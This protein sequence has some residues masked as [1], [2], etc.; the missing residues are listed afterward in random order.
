MTDNSTSVDN[1]DAFEEEFYEKP[2]EATVEATEE[3]EENETEEDSL[4]PEPEADDEEEATETDEDEES[5]EEPEEKPQP[6]KQNRIQKRIDQLL[7]RERLANERAERLEARLAA[8]EAAK[9]ETKPARQEPSLREQLPADAPD[10]DAK[11]EHGEPLY[12][13]GQFDPKYIEDITRYTFHKELEMAQS[14][15]REE[16][17]RQAYE[18]YQRQLQAE[19]VALQETWQEKLEK[20]EAEVP[21]IRE[22]LND[23]VENFGGLDPQYGEYLATTLMSLENGPEVMLYLSQNIGEAQ[24]LVAAGPYAATVAM[25]KLDER[26][27]KKSNAKPSNNRRPSKAPNPPSSQTRG[28]RVNTE[29]PIDTDNL[30]DFERVFYQKK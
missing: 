21:E 13:L 2:S 26:F 15:A 14:K 4:A 11:D 16:Q 9:T 1:L 28:Q 23:F 10:F 8:V 6:K 12:P 3:V 5:E 7:E 24:E 20:A 19:R 30:S 18:A 27:S 29:V 22:E 17:E 25:A